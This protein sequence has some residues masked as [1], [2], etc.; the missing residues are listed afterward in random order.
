[1]N[2]ESI[3]PHRT[4]PGGSTILFFEYGSRIDR[5]PAATMRE[6]V[7]I[8]DCK[9]F[10]PGANP[11]VIVG[12]PGIFDDAA[13]LPDWM[14][15]TVQNFGIGNTEHED[16]P[17]AGEQRLWMFPSIEITDEMSHF[18]VHSPLQPTFKCFKMYRRLG[19][20]YAEKVK[21]DVFRSGEELRRG[22]HFIF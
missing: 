16:R 5:S 11:A 7:P 6:Q 2:E 12:S 13:Q 18:G 21:A 10:E 9:F 19:I 3:F 8:Y 15:L 14:R 22:R 4:Q 20:D 1:M 17:N